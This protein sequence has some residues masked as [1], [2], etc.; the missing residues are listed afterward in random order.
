MCQFLDGYDL[1]N[2][3]VR[4]NVCKGLCLRYRNCESMV[5]GPTPRADV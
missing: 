1:S 2:A 3:M 5:R 4:D